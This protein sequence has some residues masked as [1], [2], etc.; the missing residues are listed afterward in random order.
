MPTPFWANIPNTLQKLPKGGGPIKCTPLSQPKLDIFAP[1]S[2]CFFWINIS[3]E[4]E[5]GV[6]IFST[7]HIKICVSLQL[8][9]LNLG[10]VTISTQTLRAIVDSFKDNAT[11][12]HYITAKW[13]LHLNSK[14]RFCAFICFDDRQLAPAK[15]L[16]SLYQTKIYISPFL[17]RGWEHLWKSSWPSI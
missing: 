17:K 9:V 16:Y 4:Q 5:H 1:I 11:S 8:Y 10:I 3:K 13:F 6:V 12:I 15:Y 7:S 14:F 2:V